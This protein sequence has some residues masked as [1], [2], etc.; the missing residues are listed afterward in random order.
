MSKYVE[1][2]IGD[3]GS[4]QIEISEEM[5]VSHAQGD[6]VKASPSL[7]DI[8]RRAKSAFSKALEITQMM[9][10]EFGNKLKELAESP[11]EVELTFGLKV[12]AS[13]S[14]LIAKAGTEGQFQVTLKWKRN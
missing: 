4:V 3:L 11:N 5:V 7:E 9:A 14:T 2:L 6:V 1:T 10:N 12:D 13:A 8:S